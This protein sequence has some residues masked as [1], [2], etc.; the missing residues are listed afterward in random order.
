MDAFGKWHLVETF[1]SNQASNPAVR[2][3]VLNTRR[4]GM[5][6]DSKAR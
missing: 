3:M 5:A 4:L 1:A 2:G 6:P